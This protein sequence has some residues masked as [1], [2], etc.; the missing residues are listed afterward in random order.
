MARDS[1]QHRI[2]QVIIRLTATYPGVPQ[3]RIADVVKTVHARFDGRPLREFVPLFV[4]R[5]AKVELRGQS[6][7]GV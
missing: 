3:A 2:Q 5:A 4:E 6:L 7:Q 1:E